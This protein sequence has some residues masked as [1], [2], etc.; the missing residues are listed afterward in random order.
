[1]K[2]TRKFS[3]TL[4]GSL[5]LALASCGGPPRQS[6]CSV[7]VYTSDRQ[8][9]VARLLDS[10]GHA[11]DTTLRVR[12]DS[13]RFQR[14]DSLAMPYM[15]SLMLIN[16]SDSMDVL[17]MPIV[18]EG[19][20]VRLSF[21]DPITLGGT[22]DNDALFSYLMAQQKF[23]RHYDE[24]NPDHDRDRL[25][26]DYSAFYTEQ[27]LRNRDNAVGRYIYDTTRQLLLPDDLERVRENLNNQKQKQR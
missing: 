25:R 3:L 12:G 6:R 7:E 27:I 17:I 1:M 26:A 24:R 8:Y 4:A 16:P 9:T 13:I 15:A 19:G 11:L 14:T 18:I 5:L 20:T 2:L 23:S 10:R 22:P 21:A